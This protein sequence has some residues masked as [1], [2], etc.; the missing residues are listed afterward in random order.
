VDAALEAVADRVVG[1]GVVLP[2]LIAVVADAHCELAL[3]PTSAH[4]GD[5]RH[6]VELRLIAMNARKPATA[7]I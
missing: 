4:L 6:S 5:V 7:K 3:A 1:K 2:V